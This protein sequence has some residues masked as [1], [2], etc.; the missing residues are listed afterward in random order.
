MLP[1]SLTGGQ[2]ETERAIKVMSEAKLIMS[3]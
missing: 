3:N 2:S 1:G